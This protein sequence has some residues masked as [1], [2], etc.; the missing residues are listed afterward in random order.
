MPW[1]C[2]GEWRYIPC[3]LSLSIIWR[4]VVSFLLWQRTSDTQWIRFKQKYTHRK[5]SGFL[6]QSY[7]YIDKWLRKWTLLQVC[8]GQSRAFMLAILAGLTVNMNAVP[9]VNDIYI[10]M[11][12][13]LQWNRHCIVITE[14]KIKWEEEKYKKK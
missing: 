6:K 2:M 8:Q 3:I 11:Y 7:Q 12:Q 14:R 1:R 13:L 4:W 5:A 9:P 10:Y